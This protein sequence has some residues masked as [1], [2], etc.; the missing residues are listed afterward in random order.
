[1]AKAEATILIN[2]PIEEVFDYTATPHNGPAF[3]PNLNENTNIEPLEPTE[4]QTFE[5]RFNMAG[6]DLR[7]QAVVSVY[8]RPNEVVL[9]ITGDTVATWSYKFEDS[10]GATKVTTAVEY[11]INENAMQKLANRAVIDKFNQKTAEQMVDNLK[12]I[13]E[14]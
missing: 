7:G 13:L 1:M 14:S 12:T 8:N 4:G 6:V 3:I 9:D 2:C 11:S 10:D 5:W